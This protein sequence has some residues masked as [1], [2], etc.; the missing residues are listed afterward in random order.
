MNNYRRLH[1]HTTPLAT[2]A[3]GSHLSKTCFWKVIQITIRL[4]EENNY[5]WASSICERISRIFGIDQARSSDE[6]WTN[7]YKIETT[8]RCSSNKRGLFYWSIYLYSKGWNKRQIK[9]KICQSILDYSTIEQFD[10]P[11]SQP[12]ESQW[13][14][15]HSYQQNSSM[16][17]IR[18]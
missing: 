1:S 3:Q 5:H 18:S 7:T 11:C 12:Y 2:P 13:N 9:S 14:Y 15:E 8:T 17:P 16:L 4:T 10:L 6:H